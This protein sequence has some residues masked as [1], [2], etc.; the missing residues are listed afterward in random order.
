[1]TISLESIERLYRLELA[2][3]GIV[4]TNPAITDDI[5]ITYGPKE[6]V[7]PSKIDGLP[8]EDW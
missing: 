1:M 3:Q 6:P 2:A 7:D 8:V 5:E 4:E